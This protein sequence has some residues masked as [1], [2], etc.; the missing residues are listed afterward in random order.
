MY[1]RAKPGAWEYECLA[2]CL[3]AGYHIE[4]RVGGGSKNLQRIH[5]FM[6]R[7]LP[8][9]VLEEEHGGRARYCQPLKDSTLSKLFGRIES[10]SS[11]LCIEDYSVSQSTLEQVFL[12]FAKAK[13]EKLEPTVDE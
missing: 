9:A 10:A 1:C 11:E 4:I 7:E 5:D 13:S 8:S 6:R 3:R 12:S 2:I